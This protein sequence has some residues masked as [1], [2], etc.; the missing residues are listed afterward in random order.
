[1]ASAFAPR[2]GRYTLYRLKDGR[3]A[4]LQRLR[5]DCP[6]EVS[7]TLKYTV[8]APHYIDVDFQCTPH[9]SSA[10]GKRGYAIFFFADYMNDVADVRLHFLGV[11]AP[12]AKEKW[13]S[14]DGPKGHPDWNGGGTYRQQKAADF[15]YD[16]DHNFKL[17]LWSYD[18][19]RYT[20][21][22]YFGRAANDMVFIIMFNKAFATEDE[23]RFS[24]FKF[25]LPKRQRP[26]WDFQ[27]VIHNVEQ[28]KDYG[29]KARVVWKKFASPE[30]CLAEYERWAAQVNKGR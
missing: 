12:D 25:K 21:P 27:Y 16:T 5:E 20:K 22:F 8:T 29:F 7:N 15:E 23:I 2:H 10:F 11:E 26:A 9:K 17:N 14:A 28:N 30:D 24:I 19:P 4:V 1:M 3:S 18:Y 6:W 13:I